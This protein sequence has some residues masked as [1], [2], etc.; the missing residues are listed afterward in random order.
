MATTRTVSAFAAKCLSE[1][2]DHAGAGAHGLV[3]DPRVAAAGLV[4]DAH[5]GAV[6]SDRDSE[7]VQLFVLEGIGSVEFVLHVASW[8]PAAERGPRPCT[9]AS[10]GRSPGGDAVAESRYR[11]RTRT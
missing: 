8:V 10:S 4:G 11:R 7:G 6:E 2:Q 3:R 1:I 5:H 9:A